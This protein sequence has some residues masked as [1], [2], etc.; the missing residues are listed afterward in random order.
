MRYI[1]TIC[2][3][4]PTWTGR[5]SIALM[6]P[7][8]IL[9]L[10]VVSA[11]LWSISSSL[12]VFPH[13]LSY[14]NELAGGPT[15]GP[16]FL[17]GS[18]CD[19]GQDLL[20][21]KRWLNDHPEARPIKFAYDGYGDPSDLGIDSVVPDELISGITEKKTI[22]IPPG[23][24][25]ISENLLRGYTYSIYKGGGAA[26]VCAKDAFSQFLS[27]QPIARAGYSIYIYHVL[28]GQ[29]ENAGD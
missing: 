16:R 20:F 18:N 8:V 15:G 23:W 2:P 19:W 25:A 10:L 6:S 21:L 12:W 28:Q 13:E 3:F 7:R 5:V 26:P 22:A 24:Y 1:L 27:L 9:R 4:I 11:L 14:F 29:R 17:L